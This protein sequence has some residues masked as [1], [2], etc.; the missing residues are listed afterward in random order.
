ML[1]I[2]SVF[3][4]NGDGFVY[5]DRTVND[6]TIETELALEDFPSPEALWMKYKYYKGI[7]ALLFGEKIALQSTFL[8][9]REENGH[10]Q[11]I[12]INR[13]VEAIANGQNRIL[14]VMA[15]GTEKPTLLSKLF[16]DF[17]KR[18]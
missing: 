18:N 9:V 6:N 8:M 16:T 10:Y 7:V 11:Q 13:T 5:H 4:S 17:G 15:T 1:D 3:S 14:L 2:P 12:A